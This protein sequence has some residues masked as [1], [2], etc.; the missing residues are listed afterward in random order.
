MEPDVVTVFGLEQAR[1]VAAAARAAG[2]EQ[3]LLV[4]IVGEEDFFYPGQVGGAPAADALAVAEAIDELEGVRFA[5]LTS[6]PCLAWDA[7]RGRL[8]ATPNLATL[9]ATAA[10]LRE[11][12][13]GVVEVNAPSATCVAVLDLLRQS[14]ATQVEP[15]SALIGNTPLHAVSDQPEVPAMVYVSE[16]THRL[17]G[18]VYALGGGHYARSRARHAR[19]F[20]RAGVREAEVRPD[21]EG[22]ID[23]HGALAVDDSDSVAVGDSVVYAFR[24]QVFVTR[25]FVA[26]VRDLEHAPEVLG[27]FDRG[28][29]A[30]GTDLL[31]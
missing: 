12:G 28:G 29:F 16:V 9:R 22:Y 19:V 17:D 5:G 4:R 26:V 11:R 2:I 27:V 24:S 8:A 25:A 6:F 15:G 21:P 10:A 23:Y 7:D 31:P 13:F 30:L 14:G 3:R 20:S 1:L 18:V